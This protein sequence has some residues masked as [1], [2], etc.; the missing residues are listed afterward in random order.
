M[1]DPM[2]AIC[3]RC[4][5]T[6]PRA[7][8]LCA[9]CGSGP[10][11][12]RDYAVSAALS[13]FLSSEDELLRYR[14]EV[15]AG[16]PPSVP[17]EVLVRAIE[18]LRDP[19][20]LGVLRSRPLGA[21]RST[22]PIA[23]APAATMPPASRPAQPV[24]PHGVAAP[25]RPESSD[26]SSVQPVGP[27]AAHSLGE[28]PFALLEATVHDSR[29]QIGE[30]AEAKAAELGDEPLR[31]ARTALT[32][33]T[34]RLDS[35]LGWLPGVAPNDVPR[36][37][38]RVHHAP[39]ELSQAAGLPTLAHLNLL[40]AAI[41]AIDGESQ[42]RD[43]AVLIQDMAN[44][45]EQLDTQAVFREINTDRAISGFAPLSSPDLLE[46]G[47][48]QRNRYYRAAIRDALDRLPSTTL[49]QVMTQAAEEATAAGERNA[50]RLI[51]ELIDRYEAEAQAGFLPMEAKNIGRLVEDTRIAAT[52]QR[53][54]LDPQVR[55]IDIVVQ[56]WS[57]VARPIQFHARARGIDH[58]PSRQVANDI[59]NLGVQLFDKHGLLEPA[60]RLMNL[61]RQHFA[62]VP[63]I[64][65]R[66]ARD[67]IALKGLARE[68]D[69]RAP[70]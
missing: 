32:H 57:M 30:L 42:A 22:A 39:L 11:T 69:R 49:V 10:R 9:S 37:L 66:A 45:V 63:A 61:L 56:N 16:V 8:D 44:L 58:G 48:A 55:A 52:D 26:A 4:G 14:D 43:L 65:E 33:P 60:L 31:Q 67:A 12:N 3:F 18:A 28:S 20:A 54:E 41:Q 62:S 7:L 2:T 40:A 34:T 51:E 6:K 68:Q 38:D 19:A 47:I 29:R 13:T 36:L 64:S 5:T 46:P 59:R 50:P 21:T 23:A 1:S 15:L 25:P 70:R 53:A 35:E 24:T 17:H 27:G